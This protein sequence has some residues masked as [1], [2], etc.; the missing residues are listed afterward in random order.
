MKQ[1]KG[2]NIYK[3]KDFTRNVELAKYTTA[4]PNG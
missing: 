3:Y 1:E 2:K 4:N